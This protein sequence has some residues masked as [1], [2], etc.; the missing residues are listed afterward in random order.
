MKMK[1]SGNETS[2]FFLIKKKKKEK[3]ASFILF[4]FISFENGE[5]SSKFIPH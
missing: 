4:K 3:K 5:K 2:E 1:N